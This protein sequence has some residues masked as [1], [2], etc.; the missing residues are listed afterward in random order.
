MSY[1]CPTILA[2]GGSLTAGFGLAASQSIAAWSAAGSEPISP[3][4]SGSA[5]PPNH[6][7]SA[8]WSTPEWTVPID[9]MSHSSRAGEG[10]VVLTE[11]SSARPANKG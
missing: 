5:S 7:L 10:I 3:R 8:A 6:R 4:V 2:F 9:G 1:G 11:L